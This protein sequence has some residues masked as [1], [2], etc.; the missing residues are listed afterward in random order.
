MKVATM[1]EPQHRQM[2]LAIAERIRDGIETLRADNRVMADELL[3][4][5]A[6]RGGIRNALDGVIA[7]VARSMRKETK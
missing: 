7:A 3:A 4:L 6:D 2:K 5:Y 1:T